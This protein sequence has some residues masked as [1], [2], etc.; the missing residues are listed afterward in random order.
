MPELVDTNP[1]DTKFSELPENLPVFP[2][3]GVLLLPRGHLPLNIFEP[4]YI[5]MVND[6]LRS[7]RMIGM[8]QPKTSSADL[9]QSGCAGRI[10]QFQETEDGRYLIT[11]K[12][13]SRFNIVEEMKT[14][15][16]YRNMR[17]DWSEFKED[18]EPVGSLGV[19]RRNLTD[20]LHVYFA[21]HDISIDW[22]LVTAVNDDKLMTCL[23]MICPFSPG[24]KQALLEAK[25]C[26][27]RSRLFM[28]LLEMSVNGSG[29][30]DTRSSQH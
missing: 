6:A 7:H 3:G 5:E 9:F 2:L 4:R 20:L 29:S 16:G 10:V 26:K 19:D 23:A 27:T 18:F 12:G 21:I 24:E 13:V 25:D 28:E 30:S 1:F 17:V 8:I 11:L 22:K 14:R 15:T